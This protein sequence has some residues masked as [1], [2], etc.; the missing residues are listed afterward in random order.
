[1]QDKRSDDETGT[2][3]YRSDTVGESVFVTGSAGTGKTILV[4]HIIKLLNKIHGPS[5]VFV[6]ASTGVAACALEGQTL[7]SFAGV[8]LAAADSKTLPNRILLDERAY[9]RWNRVKALVIDEIS[10]VQAEFFDKLEY[11]AR[12]TRD[13]EHASKNMVWGGIQLV[14]S[15]DF[16][17]LPPILDKQKLKGGK[18]F[19]FEADCWNSS[20]N[21][22]VE[23]RKIFRQ[24]D[25]QL[26][27]LLQGIRRGECD[28]EDLKLIEQCSLETEP[29]SFM[30]RFYPMNKDVNRVNDKQMVSLGEQ[31][32]EYLAIDS[33]EDPWKKQLKQGTAPNT[34]EVCVG[35]RVMLS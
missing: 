7:H 28:P 35:A 17:Q 4:H 11:I 33:G 30:V 5:H 3:E 20:F 12:E 29:D 23:L 19:A 10:M 34:L 1:M 15:G 32:V 27:K 16:F 22:Q 18:E 24:S 13:D 31:T 2:G 8:G 9:K 21:M 6:T 26:I 25:G 14:V